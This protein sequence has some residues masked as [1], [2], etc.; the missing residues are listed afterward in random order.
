MGRFAFLTAR[1]HHEHFYIHCNS[2]DADIV[3]R[4]GLQADVSGRARV[5][6]VCVR[7]PARTKS[8]RFAVI[9]AE[10]ELGTWAS[11]YRG[12]PRAPRTETPSSSLSH[13]DGDD[14]YAA[15]GPLTT[16]A[17]LDPSGRVRAGS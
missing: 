13:S 10:S 12:R 5:Q 11:S 7:E 17:A 14:V 15:G 8:L 4:D 16:A 2:N 9:Q 6:R 3:L 1:N